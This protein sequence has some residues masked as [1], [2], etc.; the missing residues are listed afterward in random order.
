VLDF[1]C[2][3]GSTCVHAA[4]AGADRVV[5]L[6][7]QAVELPRRK[8][9]TEFP[10]LAGRVEFRRIDPDYVPNGDRF[11]LV[12]SKNSF[13]HVADPERHVASMRAHLAPGGQ[14]A[15]GFAPLWKSPWGGHI[16]FM[17]SLPWAHLLF[18]ERI[19]LAERRRFRPEEDAR[20]YEDIL[21]GLNRMTLA[22]F[23]AVMAEAG[24]EQLGLR[25]N[26]AHSAR[27][28]G[29]NAAL[30]AMAALSRV[31]GLRE[32]FSFSVYGVWRASS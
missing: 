5:G 1:G 22:R 29:R 23:Q 16:D 27:S 7:I 11:D 6:D 18:P 24:L 8:L 17:T 31:P 10:Q 19:V 30:A 2:G 21:G 20:R 13:E 32:Y 3:L 14:L 15:I 9:A 26:P 25:T 12:L 4:L 28:P